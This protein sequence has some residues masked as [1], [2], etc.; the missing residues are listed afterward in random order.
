MTEQSVI[1]NKT[2]R[3]NSYEF[4]S[5]GNRFKIYFD[6]S[7]ELTRLVKDLRDDGFSVELTVGIDL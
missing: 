4:G 5:A 2:E 7:A 6:T 1:L 3:P